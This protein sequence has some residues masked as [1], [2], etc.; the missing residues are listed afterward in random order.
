MKKGASSPAPFAIY[1]LRI[2]LS[3][4]R[5]GITAV[6][7]LDPAGAVASGGPDHPSK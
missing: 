2:F 5:T 7:R 1:S 3:Y 6:A 4:S